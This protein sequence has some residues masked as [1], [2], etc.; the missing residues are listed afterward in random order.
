[1]LRRAEAAALTWAD[2][3]FRRDGSARGTDEGHLVVFDLRPGRSWA[4]RVYREDR[5]Q[6][7]GRITVWGA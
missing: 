3:E 2:V 5:G 6:D 4:E 1:M 7:G